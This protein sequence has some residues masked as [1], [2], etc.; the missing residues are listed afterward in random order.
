M[1][2]K[3]AKEQKFQNMLNAYDKHAA[4]QSKGLF[5]ATLSSYSSL[6][7]ETFMAVLPGV[8]YEAQKMGFATF[9]DEGITFY[10]TSGLLGDG[11]EIVGFHRIPYQYISSMKSL[12]R[13]VSS[14]EAFEIFFSEQGKVMRINLQGAIS[15]A[16]SFPNYTENVEVLRRILKFR[17]I[18]VKGNQFWK[19]FVPVFVIV[20]AAFLWYFWRWIF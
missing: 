16:K 7:K 3:I 13:M 2:E 9:D 8:E 1:E 10:E 17:N 19:Y 18:E 5:P 15:T 11:K 6:V 20:L 4:N 14:L 12:G